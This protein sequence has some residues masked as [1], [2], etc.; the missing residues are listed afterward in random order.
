MILIVINFI[1]IQKQKIMDRRLS[2]AIDTDVFALITGKNIPPQ[3]K[4]DI[5]IDIRINFE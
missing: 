3:Q 5:F 4:N 2:Q 1:D